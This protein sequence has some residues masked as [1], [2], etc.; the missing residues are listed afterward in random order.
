MSSPMTPPSTAKLSV[1]LKLTQVHL[2]V[3]VLVLSLLFVDKRIDLLHSG[4]VFVVNKV[5]LH[6]SP[7]LLTI[8]FLFSTQSGSSA[9]ALLKSTP[10]FWSISNI[11]VNPSSFFINSFSLAKLQLLYFT[12]TYQ[13]LWKVSTV[14]K[15]LQLPRRQAR[16]PFWITLNYINTFT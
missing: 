1:C 2:R 6:V 15:S 13:Y 9:D 8:C 7:K 14:G 3:T 12:H 4:D 10:V 11:E 16:F 5:T